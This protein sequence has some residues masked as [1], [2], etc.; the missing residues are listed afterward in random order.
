MNKPAGF[1]LDRSRRFL[2]EAKDERLLQGSSWNCLYAAAGAGEAF[3]NEPLSDLLI[4]EAGR[5]IYESQQ[6]RLSDQTSFA[7]RRA[8]RSDDVPIEFWNS[9][10][11]DARAALALIGVATQKN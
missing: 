5:R 7:A 8:W 9:Y 11:E 2:A 4:E 10:C 6:A 3:V 1:D